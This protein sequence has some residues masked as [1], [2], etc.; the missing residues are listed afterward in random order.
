MEEVIGSIPIRSTNKPNNLAE[1]SQNAR[2]HFARISSIR[3]R[4][5]HAICLLCSFLGRSTL[6]LFLRFSS[7][8]CTIAVAGAAVEVSTSE[9]A[10]SFLIVSW[11]SRS[12]ESTVAWTQC[13]GDVQPQED[14]TPK[15]EFLHGCGEMVPCEHGLVGRPQVRGRLQLAR[16][17]L[18]E[19]GLIDCLR[20]DVA[21]VSPDL[22]HTVLGTGLGQL[23]EM[24]LQ[25][26]P[27]EVFETIVCEEIDEVCLNQILLDLGSLFPPVLPSEAGISTALST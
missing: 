8:H 26:D 11:S 22:Q 19:E 25:D 21:H 10:D 16:R 3:V 12:S 14:A 23:V 5:D 6:V 18:R 9:L 17:V 1:P 4:P 15:I 2:P 7:C 24:G 20:K 13:V 27:V